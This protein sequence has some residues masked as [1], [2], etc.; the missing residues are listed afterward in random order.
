MAERDTTL[1]LKQSITLF[2][3]L[4]TAIGLASYLFDETFVSGILYGF[5]MAIIIVIYYYWSNVLGNPEYG[6]WFSKNR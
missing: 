2:L 4:P 3:T 1:A 5:P 6:G